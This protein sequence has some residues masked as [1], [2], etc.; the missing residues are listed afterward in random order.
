MKR[1]TKTNKRRRPIPIP[2]IISLTVAPPGWYWNFYVDSSHLDWR[3]WVG[4]PMHSLRFYT[5]MKNR[6]SK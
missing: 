3:D 5:I 2:P 4:R 6:T 1:V